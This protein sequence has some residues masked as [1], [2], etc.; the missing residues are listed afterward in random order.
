M[1]GTGCKFYPSAV[2]RAFQD[3]EAPKDEEA[4]AAAPS[5][6]QN[7]AVDRVLEMI[8]FSQLFGNPD[9]APSTWAQGAERSSCLTHD[10]YNE[11][12]FNFDDCYHTILASIISYITLCS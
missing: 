2:D 3:T 4:T 7:S 11:V 5:D 10:Q 12:P 8:Y 1:S 9:D 6:D